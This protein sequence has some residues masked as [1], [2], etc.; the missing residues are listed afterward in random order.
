MTNDH[1]LSEFDLDA[2]SESLYNELQTDILDTVYYESHGDVTTSNIWEII[3]REGLYQNLTENPRTAF[4]FL[5]TTDHGPTA[6]YKQYIDL[7]SSYGDL[8]TLIG[9]SAL[10]NDI[11]H[12]KS[13]YLKNKRRNIARNALGDMA[14]ASYAGKAR[15]CA[16]IE[17][18]IG[19]SIP[20]LE[21]ISDENIQSEDS[22]GVYDYP[23]IDFININENLEF[24][25]SAQHYG[26]S[27]DNESGR[28]D[29]TG[30]GSAY[31][32]ITD[33]R[34]VTVVGRANDPDMVLSLRIPFIDDVT[35]HIGLAKD[36]LEIDM[37][38]K[39]DDDGPY[40][41]W[42]SDFNNVDIDDIVNQLNNSKKV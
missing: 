40:H 13:D 31:H 39:D 1:W 37:K 24:F 11:K 10:V 17:S 20:A 27:V 16:E 14:E 4:S 28:V 12:L 5:L 32:M 41:I 6:D 35:T 2:K 25:F 30:D 33:R 26:Y 8:I 38:S 42:V 29:P 18:Y 9:L 36:R 23:L 22:V 34:V 19:E 15:R 21:Y 3:I 7:T